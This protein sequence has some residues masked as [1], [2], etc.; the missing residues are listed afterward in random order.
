MEVEIRC[1]APEEHR[2]RVEARASDIP[3]LM[4]PT[5]ADVVAREYHLWDR[6]HLVIESASRTIDENVSLIRAAL[7][8]ARS[9]SPNL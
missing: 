8:E 4:M 5:W 6:E 9:L 3:G 7:S 2:R 1:S